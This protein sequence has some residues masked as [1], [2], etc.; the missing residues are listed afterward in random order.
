MIPMA[1]SLIHFR[2]FKDFQ[3][4]CNYRKS[5]LDSGWLKMSENGKSRQPAEKQ[6]LEDFANGEHHW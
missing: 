4:S 5:A 1:E 3:R 6:Q 2:Q